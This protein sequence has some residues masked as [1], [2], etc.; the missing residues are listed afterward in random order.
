VTRGAQLIAQ[1]NLDQRIEVKTH[2]EIQTLGET[3]NQMTASLRESIAARERAAADLREL[4][5]TLEDRV[6]ERTRELQALADRLEQANRELTEL[7]RLKTQFLANVSH[8]FKTPLTSIQAFSEILVDEVE[9]GTVAQSGEAGRFLGIIHSESQRLGR[10]IRNL[11]SLSQIE[12]GR[13][14]WHVSRFPLEEAVDAALDGVLPLLK[15][16]GIAVDRVTEGDAA[17]VEAD[18]DR[19]QEVAT[20][21][22]DN[23]VKFSGAEGRIALR[24]R[25]TGD[26]GTSMVQVTVRDHGCGIPPEKQESIFDRFSQVDPSD[27]REKG[28]TGLG[29][30]ICREIV[31]H[32]GGRIWV[33]SAPGEGAAFHFTLPVA[34]GNGA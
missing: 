14:V 2:D 26:N 30:A 6:E 12:S 31:E 29:L 34:D 7:D 19:I 13:I 10:L 18:R 24:T 5:A 33:E 8:E 25:I 11:L 20:N 4:N 32:H 9:D 22:L 21:L 3:F 1:G 28:G 17:V 16:K 23:A 27:T 15:E